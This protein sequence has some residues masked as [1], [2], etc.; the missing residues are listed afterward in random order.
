MPAKEGC[1]R[2]VQADLTRGKREWEGLPKTKKY[3]C[4]GPKQGHDFSNADRTDRATRE[5]VQ[6]QRAGPPGVRTLEIGSYSG[7]DS[8]PYGI[9]SGN[10]IED[11]PV[12][13]VYY[14]ET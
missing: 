3:E 6:Y 10:H 2:T 13:L 8:R 9:P 7:L 11:R 1:S 14:R 5:R 4:G 12:Y